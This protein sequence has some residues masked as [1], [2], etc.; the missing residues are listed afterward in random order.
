MRGDET[1]SLMCRIQSPIEDLSLN[2][3]LKCLVKMHLRSGVLI[4]RSPFQILYRNRQNGYIPVTNRFPYD[5]DHSWNRLCV[6]QF[7]IDPSVEAISTIG[8]GWQ[9]NS[10]N[11]GLMAEWIPDLM[12]I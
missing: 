10:S 5:T 9:L 1:P 6:A 4:A 8:G 7:H 2:Q 12:R 11:I 3:L